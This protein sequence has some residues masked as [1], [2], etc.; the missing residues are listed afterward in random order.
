MG[1]GEFTPR[2]VTSEDLARHKQELI[3][4]FPSAKFGWF[5]DVKPSLLKFLLSALK[6]GSEEAIQKILT[7]NPYLIQYAVKSSGHHGIWVFPKR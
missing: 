1:V 6:A 7:A 4:Q 3:Q 2:R 5:P